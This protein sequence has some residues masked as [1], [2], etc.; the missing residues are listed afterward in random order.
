MQRVIIAIL[1]ILLIIVVVDSCKTKQE[2]EIEILGLKAKFEQIET[3]L[4]DANKKIYQ[5]N[6]LFVDSRAKIE[7]LSDS[8]KLKKTDVHIQFRD[9]FVI[10][11]VKIPVVEKQIV[12]I[13]T[14]DYLKI[15]YG[16]TQEDGWYKIGGLI[17]RTSVDLSLSVYSEGY[18]SIGKE[19]N[20]YVVQYRNNNP[21][22]STESVKSV[23]F[24]PKPRK[25]GLGLSVGYGA[26]ASGLTPY[27]GLGVNYSIVRF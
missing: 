9:R 15:P 22:I 24:K 18:I 25:L 7:A 21:Y 12:T 16:F 3:T 14:T 11:T 10:D 1:S 26:T 5:S 19:K 8:L 6:V 20:S 2:K 4:V 27:V 17:T 23:V 13:D